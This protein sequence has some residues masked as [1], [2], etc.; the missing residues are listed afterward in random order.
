M[1]QQSIHNESDNF[2]YI[3]EPTEEDSDMTFDSG[4]YTKNFDGEKITGNALG[5]SLNKRTRTDN[6]G[7][8][9]RLRFSRI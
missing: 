1:Q 5:F 3:Y 8:V 9:L 4:K 7:V 2:E 6:F